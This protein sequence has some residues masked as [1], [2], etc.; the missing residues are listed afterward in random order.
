E[1][2]GEFPQRDLIIFATAV[3][4]VLT[5]AVQGP[6]L[7]PLI[8]WAHLP[9]DDGAGEMRL[10]RMESSQAALDALPRLAEDLGVDDAVRVKITHEIERHLVAL[11]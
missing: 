9:V 3:V 2:G 11:A 8:R 5:L 1:S 4:I 7:L 6:L 10:A